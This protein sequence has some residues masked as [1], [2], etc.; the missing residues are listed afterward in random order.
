MMPQEIGHVLPDFIGQGIRC[1]EGTGFIRPV[2]FHNAHNL[3]RVNLDVRLADAVAGFE[4]GDFA[5]VG[6][7]QGFVNVVQAH[8]ALAV[9]GV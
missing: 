8:G 5:A 1:G 2:G 4:D 9:G 3:F 6:R 7:I